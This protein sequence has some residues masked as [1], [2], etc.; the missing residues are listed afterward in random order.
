MNRSIHLSLLAL[1]CALLVAFSAAPGCLDSSSPAPAQRETAPTRGSSACI[2]GD[3]L[4]LTEDLYPFNYADSDGTLHGQSVE[5]VQELQRRLNCST[6]IELHSW[7]ASYESAM[8]NQG[9]AVFSTARTAEREGKFWWVGP[10]GSFEYVL[11]ARNDSFIQLESL[12]AARRAGSIAVVYGDARHEFLT[13]NQ[14]GNIQPYGNDAEC[15]DALMN[16]S[17]SLWIG[18]SATTPD[19]LQKGG[20]PD[21]TI[22]PVYTLLTTDLYI[23]FNNQTAPG[24]I[25]LYQDTLDAMKADG[26]FARITGIKS[27]ARAFSQSRD[28]PAGFPEE[29]ILS[30]I[31]AVIAARMHGMASAMESLALT[32]ELQSGDWEKVRPILM[33]L[34]SKYPEARFWYAHPDG[35]YYTTVDNLTSANLKDRPYFPGVIGGKTSIGTIVVSKSTGRYTAIIAVPV[36]LHGD[37]TTILGTSVY[38]D[39][40]ED[41]LDDDIPLPGDY[42]FFVLDQDGMP[43]LDSL[44]GRI[45]SLEGAPGAKMQILAGQEGQV[46]YTYEGVPNRALYQTE[47]ITGWKVAIAW[48]V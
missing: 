24:T 38:C 2:G 32:S 33:R 11:F 12:E 22:V 10:I 31:S 39:T 48:K 21:G 13:M 43:V 37:V 18:S 6:R 30:A 40:L 8:H 20:I 36:F 19:T 42:Y 14:F 45:F 28:T 35:S 23:A 9:T 16:G 34:E 7:S 17:V 15:L 47:N 27:A 26:T 1:T 25:T 5:V 3:I 41:M 29:A 4:F 44:P 46:E